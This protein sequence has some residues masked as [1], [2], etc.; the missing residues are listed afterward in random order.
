MEEVSDS[1]F[2]CDTQTIE[3]G[4]LSGDTLVQIYDQ[5]VRLIS[6][7][8]QIQ[9]WNPVGVSKIVKAAVNAS[10]IFVALDTGEIIYLELE[11]SSVISEVFRRSVGT[12]V[13]A[14]CLSMI[15]DGR[16]RSKFLVV[17]SA[18]NRIR[19]FKIDDVANPFN[20]I[21]IQD[22]TNVPQSA[23][24]FQTSSSLSL[25]IGLRNG[26]LFRSK[27]DETTGQLLDTKRQVLG[28]KPVNLGALVVLGQPAIIA[29]SSRSYVF[30]EQRSLIKNA[31]LSYEY[32]ESASIFNSEQCPDGLV[33]ISESSLRI[34]SVDRFSFFNSS[35]YKLPRTPRKLVFLPSNGF[36]I[37][38]EYDHCCYPTE[39]K[40]KLAYE[41]M[42]ISQDDEESISFVTGPRAKK[43]Q[44]S[45]SL[46]IFDPFKGETS[47]ILELE[48]NE[49]PL[50]M[51]LVEFTENH[52]ILYLAVG[53]AKDLKLQP[54][55]GTYFVN[56]YKV[57]DDGTS[58]SFV[59]STPV[60]N[61]PLAMHP[62]QGRLL[63]GVGNILRIYDIG[64][65]RL[66]R[67]SENRVR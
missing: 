56:L 60:E 59:H 40:S 58:L 63:V 21:S 8:K 19:V 44:W 23:V 24:F 42:D 15:P 13:T 50:S 34:F 32:L 27:L 20:Q 53:V 45:G 11:N 67:K 47:F 66:L 46:R 49:V 22:V 12:E 41:G 54:R 39:E 52:G 17:G 36:L 9:E 38:S 48:A 43:G 18:D 35:I 6:P 61:C 3:V 33:A 16:M 26:M 64:K 55:S 14:L 10:Q 5:G 25:F 51:T 31:P 30:W 62:F 28:S 57:V 37:I 2:K 7:D 65:K 29:L 1:S 4:I